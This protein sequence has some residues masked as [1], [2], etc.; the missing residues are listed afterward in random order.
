[1]E[2]LMDASPTIPVTVT[3]EAAAHV[4]QLG[5]R[6]EL[7]QMLEY[8]RQT[9]PGLLRLDVVLAPPYDTGDEDSVVIEATRD[10]ASRLANDPTWR[11]WSKWRAETFSPDV[12]RHFAFLMNYE[13]GHAG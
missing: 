3:P 5:M 12:G 6:K 9:I 8:A 10:M 11:Q 4:A 2:C 13:A 7:E 1:M